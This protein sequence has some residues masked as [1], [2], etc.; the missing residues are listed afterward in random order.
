MRYATAIDM[1]HCMAPHSC[2]LVA[3]C[4][5]YDANDNV[6]IAA[7]AHVPAEDGEQCRWFMETLKA[8]YLR[9]T[10]TDDFCTISDQEKVISFMRS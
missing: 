2:G 7:F 5:V 6:H 4:V 9:M 10:N 1:A 8:A 3:V